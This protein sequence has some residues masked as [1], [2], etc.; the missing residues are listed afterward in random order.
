MA[1]FDVHQHLWPEE[2]MDALADRTS[3]P[4]LDGSTLILD[5][6][7]EFP[8]DP[9]EHKLDHRFLDMDRDGTEVA[10]ISLQPTLGVEELPSVE[11]EPLLAAWHEG[12]RRL[13]DAGGGRLRAL[14]SGACLPGFAGTCVPA[15]SVVEGGADL[16]RLVR[17]LIEERQV[18]FVHPGPGRPPSGALPWW[19]AV[20]DY[21]AQMQTAYLA[22]LVRGARGDPRPP[23]IFAILAGGGPFQ[24]ERLGT[25]GGD[26]GLGL[27]PDVFLEVSSYGRHAI[28]LC[29]STF[30]A[31]QL[32][33]G[34]DRPVIDPE[35]TLRA[36]RSL[37]GSFETVIREENALLLFG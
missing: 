26:P 8:F 7:G 34:S 33:Y 14:A 11:R 30:G 19:S 37:G 35:T 24:L 5:A 29:H 9:T 31:R 27:D 18:L 13:V 32:L 3:P 12:A 16:D 20:A 10:V 15:S 22:W 21:T 4:R 28:E 1:T 17:Q 23:T 2:L 36:V 6:E 25:R